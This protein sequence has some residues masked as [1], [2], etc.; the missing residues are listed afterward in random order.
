M[1]LLRR[2]HGQKIYKP[3]EKVKHD[4]FKLT[5]QLVNSSSQVTVVSKLHRQK[6]SNVSTQKR[7][8]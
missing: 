5:K 4:S 7:Q 8:L 3:N 1:C 6:T 2:K